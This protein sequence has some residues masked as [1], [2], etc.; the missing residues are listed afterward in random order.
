M[1]PAPAVILAPADRDKPRMRPR[2]SHED[3]RQRL[4]PSLELFESALEGPIALEE[5]A[6][7]CCLSPFHFHR[8]FS[9]TIGASPAS[10]LRARRLSCAARQVLAGERSVVELAF[11]WGYASGEAF[12]RAFRAQFHLNPGEYR[13]YGLSLFLRES[14][15][16]CPQDVAA[17]SRQDATHPEWSPARRM[18]GL[19]LRGENDHPAN[20]RRLYEFLQIHPDGNRQRWTIADRYVPAV[21]GLRYEFFVGLD[22]NSLTDVPLG[23]EALELPCRPE[24]HVDF[25]GSVDELHE[26]LPSRIEERLQAWKLE[27]PPLSWKLEQVADPVRWT[28]C[29]FRQSLEVREQ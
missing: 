29:A 13:R 26:L 20:M 22:A 4:R 2:E 11:R 14:E 28:R 25:L 18:V 24:V 5:A 23:L 7:Q 19:H 16:D 12:S 15:L 10:Y 17:P 8:L 27:Q 1:A 3:I 9:R 6:W 21:D